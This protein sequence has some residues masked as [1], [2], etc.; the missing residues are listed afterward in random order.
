MQKISLFYLFILKIELILESHH[1]T[2]N[3]HFWSH[4]RL[5][6]STSF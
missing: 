4:Q 2:G 6:F 3:I 5:K 1:M